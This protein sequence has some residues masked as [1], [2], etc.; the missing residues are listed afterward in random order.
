[1]ARKSGTFKTID[2]VAKFLGGVENL[3]NTVV[4]VGVP[5][6]KTTRKEGTALTNA[7]LAYIHD[8]GAPEANIPARPFMEPGIR[9]VQKEITD[10]MVKAGNAALG[11]KGAQSVGTYLNRVGIIASRSIKAVIGAGIPPPLAPSTIAGRIRRIK[12]KKR[13]Q[14]ITDAQAAGIPDSRQMGMEGIFTPLVVTAQLRNAITY[15]L[16]DQ[17]KRKYKINRDIRK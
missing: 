16:R 4:M 5:S 13:R 12:G 15:V 8:K 17:F 6:D 11:T 9:A 14:K 2:N 3:A 7:D 1:M 10:E